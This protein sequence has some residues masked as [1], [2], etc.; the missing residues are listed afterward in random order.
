MKRALFI[1]LIVTA[2]LSSI[3]AFAQRTNIQSNTKLSQVEEIKCAIA[4]SITSQINSEGTYDARLEE[5]LVISSQDELSK[6]HP[7]F[8]AFAG[9]LPYH[10]R[11]FNLS[12]FE[13]QDALV[14][15][16]VEST[17]K[18]KSNLFPN[19]INADPRH[20]ASV[21]NKHGYRYAVVVEDLGLQSFK[22]NTVIAP[23]RI[24]TERGY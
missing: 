24:T 11:F 10:Q 6:E 16:V 1:T 17:F 4:Q 9:T 8:C 20:E 12:E 3:E 19:S 22:I 23:D 21:E 15:A 7:E 13:S 2:K 14:E 18:H 5:I